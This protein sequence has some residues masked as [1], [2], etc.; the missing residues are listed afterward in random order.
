MLNILMGLVL[1]IPGILSVMSLGILVN[2][3]VFKEPWEKAKH[4]SVECFLVGVASLM[5]ITGFL[6]ICWG[7]GGAFLTHCI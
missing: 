4:D 7:I 6:W 2:R 5:I 3:Y 1:V